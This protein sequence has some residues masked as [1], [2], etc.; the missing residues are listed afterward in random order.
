MAAPASE[1]RVKVK[2]LKPGDRV[3]VDGQEALVH[4]AER[5]RL[6]DGDV[7]EVTVISGPNDK[8]SVGLYDGSAVTLVVGA[9]S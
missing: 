5:N 4:S 2:D 1:K 7:W 3:R 9:P 8:Y 6:F